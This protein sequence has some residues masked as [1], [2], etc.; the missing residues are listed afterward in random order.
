MSSVRD[1]FDEVEAF[2]PTQGFSGVF[3]SSLGKHFDDFLRGV[4]YIYIYREFAT[5]LLKSI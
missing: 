2:P 4:L 5:G 3:L 1:L